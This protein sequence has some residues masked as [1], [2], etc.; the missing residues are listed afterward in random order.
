[1]VGP[2]GGMVNS[3][4]GWVTVRVAGLAQWMKG[5]G[6]REEKGRVGGGGVGMAGSELR[7][8]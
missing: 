4:P 5:D 7:G 8:G 2:E 3:P 6:D 1:M